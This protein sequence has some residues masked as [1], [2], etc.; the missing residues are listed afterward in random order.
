MSERAAK[1]PH[2]EEKEREIV[3]AAKL[4]KSDTDIVVHPKGH[5]EDEEVQSVD[6]GESGAEDYSFDE[7][8]ASGDDAEDG[9]DEEEGAEGEA[10]NGDDDEEEEEEDN[11]DEEEE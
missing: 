3:V 2:S 7:D 5:P 8:G 6:S 1:R 4:S 9:N 10:D 11:Q